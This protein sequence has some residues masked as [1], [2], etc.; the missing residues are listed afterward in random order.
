MNSLMEGQHLRKAWRGGRSGVLWRAWSKPRARE[1]SPISGVGVWV[2][3]VVST[4]AKGR[5]QK[6]RK[7]E[8]CR[9]TLRIHKYSLRG[10]QHPG[11]IKEERQELCQGSLLFC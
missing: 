5:I 11:K 10:H 9:L 1:S 8:S 7:W 4:A 3:R 2:L 6:P